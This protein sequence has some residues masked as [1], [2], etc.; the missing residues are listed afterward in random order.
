M[1]KTKKSEKVFVPIIV[2]KIKDKTKKQEEE[3]KMVSLI[4]QITSWNSNK[5]NFSLI[6]CSPIPMGTC[7]SSLPPSNHATPSPTGTGN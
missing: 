6:S 2:N 5:Q 1:N 3:E 4:Q 7:W